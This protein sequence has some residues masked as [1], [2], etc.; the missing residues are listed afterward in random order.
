MKRWVASAVAVAV[1]LGTAAW[2]WPRESPSAAIEVTAA[3]VLAVQEPKRSV[4]NA[5]PVELTVVAAAVVVDAGALP[6][7]PTVAP[8]SVDASVAVFDA[9]EVAASAAV[10][11]GSLHSLL[12]E[13]PPPA[14]EPVP[15]KDPRFGVRWSLKGLCG[16]GFEEQLRRRQALLSSF[17]LMTLSG[18]R[19]FYDPSVP[20]ERVL[21][22]GE[23][24]AAGRQQA[25]KLLGPEAVVAAP[26]VYLYANA[27]ALRDTSCANQVTAGYYDGSLHL[28]AED[29][30]LEKTVVHENIHHVLNQL[31]VPKP[32]W[33]HEGLAMFAA[34]ERWW[35]DP[36]LGLAQWLRAQHLPFDGL[37]LAFPH[38]SDERFAF[39]VYY[40]SLRMVE[41]VFT[42]S[43]SRDGIY[44]LVAGLR[45]GSIAPQRAFAQASGVGSEALELQWRAFIESR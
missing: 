32:M 8:D 38:S 25:V 3:P 30:E 43:P 26:D 45:D 14:N 18:A 33:L 16:P 6:P 12:A 39:G 35:Q 27:E 21:V 13:Q 36:R 2:L 22:V 5:A 4:I 20:A 40:Q 10:D 24:L 34:K 11:A 28:H 19:V 41:F 29:P 31:G 44:R 37:A 15:G 7:E 9:G 17:A 1:A 23:A 42:R